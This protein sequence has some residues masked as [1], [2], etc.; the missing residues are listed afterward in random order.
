MT[1][2]PIVDTTSGRLQGFTHAEHNVHVFMGIPYA[3]PPVGDRRYRPPEPYKPEGDPATVR[4]C[5]QAGRAAPQTQMPFDTLMSI[6]IDPDNQSEDCLYINVWTPTV[7]PAAKL[8]VLFWI[9]TGACMSGCG[10]Q[11]FWDGTNFARKDVVVVT[12]NYR[13][14][15]LGWMT[16]D[17]LSND[18]DG[19]A[20][21]GLLDQIVAAEWVK[22]NIATFG[23]DPNNIT[24][25]GSSAGAT[26]LMAMLISPRAG[27]F[28]ERVILQSPPMFHFSPRDWAK[29][30]GDIFIRSMGISPD[31]LDELREVDVQTILDAQSFMTTWPNFL[32]GLAPVGPAGDDNKT[33][34]SS[35]IEYYFHHPLPDHY[36]DLDIIIGYTR[37]EFNFF[38]PFLPN[39]QEMDDTMFVRTYF[40]HVFGRKYARE[41]YEIY[42]SQ[43]VPP[44]SPP[45]EVAR[46]MC[47]DV[48]CRISVLL[49]AEN[50]V[51]HGHKVHLYEW[52]Y[53][54]NDVENIIK[55][56]HM[57]DAIFSWDNLHFWEGNPFLGPGDE[58]ERDRIAK[59]VSQAIVAFA[60]TGSPNH[61]GIP[62]WPLYDVNERKAMIFWQYHFVFSAGPDSGT[63]V[64]FR[65]LHLISIPQ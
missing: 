19:S 27:R 62:H 30:K 23:G 4:Q 17:H 59:Q 63:S 38:F 52:R 2:S 18:F 37:D 44:F 51:K 28:F 45:S 53:E 36:K 16:L 6:Q 40:A 50:L 33:L 13:L 21:Y 26:C 11:S 49:T 24:G 20:N 61:Q 47:S 10:D 64:R 48:M 35:L 31:Q 25:Y 57:V 15:A 58:Y 8:P 22:D 42:K 56:A 46:Y 7:D 1:G 39:F 3:M 60:N 5:L 34:P 55:A 41:A 32:E 65:F 54:S 9:H 14:G 12:F 29:F 43:I